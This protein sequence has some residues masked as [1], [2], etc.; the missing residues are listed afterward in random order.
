VIAA[1]VAWKA[2]NTISGITTPLEKVA[3]LAYSPL[4]TSNAPLRNKRSFKLPK[5]ALPSVNARL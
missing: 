1:N 3:A 4:A 2:M 5:N